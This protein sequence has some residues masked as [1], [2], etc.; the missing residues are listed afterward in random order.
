[1]FLLSVSTS[2]FNIHLSVYPLTSSS[3]STSIHPYVCL[4]I[5]ISLFIFPSS[6]MFYYLL[7]WTNPLM[8]CCGKFLSLRARRHRASASW[9]SPKCST[10]WWTW[11]EGAV[12]IMTTDPASP[13]G[14]AQGKEVTSAKAEA[15]WSHTGS[16]HKQLF[17][18]YCCAASKHMRLCGLYTLR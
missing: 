10:S 16:K 4:I 12:A 5:F 11:V 14:T 2:C 15:A 13:S 17:A 8:G 1:M 3:V 9:A 18:Y 7:R 6:C